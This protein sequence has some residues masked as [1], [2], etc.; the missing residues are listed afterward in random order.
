MILKPADRLKSASEYYFSMKLEEIRRMREEGRDVINLGIGSPDLMPAGSVIEKASTALRSEK[1][2]AYSSYRSTPEL[3]GAISKWYRRDF[4]VELNAE[5]EIL[6]LLGSK[7]GIL[8][9]SLAYLN[10]G[11]EV[12]VPNPGYP[13]YTSVA[14]LIGARVRSY[15]LREETGWLPDLAELE[16]TDLSRTKILWTNYPHMPT[17]TVGTDELF[18]E[19]IRFGKKHRILIAN[20]N[21]YGLILNESPPRSILSFDPEKETS[22]ELNSLSKSFNMAGW[23][24]GMA[25]GHQDVIQAVLQVKSNVDSGMFIPVQ[26]GAA[27]A[28]SLPESWHAER[29]GIYR[30]RRGKVWKILDALGF[31]Y[32]KDQVGLF[33][34]AKAPSAIGDVGVF[35]DRLLQEAN[36][37]L[38]P[39][40]IFGS[41][42]ARYVRVSLCAS[43]AL[44]DQALLRVQKFCGKAAS[45]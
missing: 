22:I 40:F 19:L 41:N 17:G 6:P 44:L 12:L 13:A 20:D 36:V 25:L 23:R 21:P 35:I 37:F 2:H 38:T 11:D 3:R 33:V 5:T 14:N 7:E 4:G 28:L 15:D 8:Y 1:N 24:V 18:R 26:Q 29:N 31:A 39:G 42:G 9:L 34:W 27:E 43:D 32:A 30:A 45:S 16:R 10:P